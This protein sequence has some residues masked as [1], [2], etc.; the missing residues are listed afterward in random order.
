MIATVVTHEDRLS[1]TWDDG[2]TC[3]YHYTWLRDNCTCPECRHPDAWERLY[4]TAAM[5]ANPVPTSVS[6]NGALQLTWPDGHLTTMSPA[7][8]RENEYGP[9]GRR[10][11]APQPV[12]WDAS[13]ADNPPEISFQEIDS[14]TEGMLRWLTL[15]RDYGFSLIRA[16]PIEPDAVL[17]LAERISFVQDTNFGHTFHV[18]SKPDPENLAYTSHKLNAHSDIPNRHSSVNLQFLHCLEFDAEGGESLLVDGFAVAQR[19]AKTHP[20]AYELLTKV[21][22]PWRFQDATTDIANHAP[23]LDVDGDGRL[24]QVRYHTALMAPLD[25]DPELVGPV[26]D[27]I[28]AFGQALRDPAA[29]FAFKMAPGDC[30]V[31]DNVRVL[32]GRAEFNPASGTRRLQGCYLDRDDFLGK[33]RALERRGADFRLR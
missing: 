15:I 17:A 8:L 21:E 27:A 2:S 26:Y 30:Q 22:L 12:L 9:Q 1:V 18:I 20:A 4:D 16:V 11:R 3:D 10:A 32:H 31:F 29:E 19:F 25:V 33:L 14:G 23:V 24:R 13:I 6:A 28:R 5:P 7:W